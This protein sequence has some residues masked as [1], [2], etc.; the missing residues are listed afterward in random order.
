[1]VAHQDL[2][3]EQLDVKTAFLHGELEED[4]YMA[5]PDG[6]QV[7]GK[8]KYVCRLKK[9]LYGLKQSPRQW[10]KRFD[11]YMIQLGYNRSP[12]DCCV[13]HNKATN[14]SFIYLVLYVDDMLIAAEHKSDV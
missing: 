7:P 13:Y 1:M 5:Q 8:E 2:E 3:L 10:Y 14:G 9:S 11:T 4:I 12:Y 6:F